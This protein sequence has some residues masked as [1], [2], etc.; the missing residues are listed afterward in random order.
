[1]ANLTSDNDDYSA[2]NNF[3]MR[4]FAFDPD[5]TRHAAAIA[6]LFM[7]L[8]NNGGLNSFLT[9]T[10]DLDSQEVVKALK[11]VGALKAAEQLGKVLD[12]LGQPL[13][14]SSP[15]QRWEVLERFWT[16]ELEEYET[17]SEAADRELMLV[18][19][20]HVRDYEPFYRAL[21]KPIE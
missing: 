14:A 21:G 9:S 13:P 15:A 8:A 19:E 5:E 11:F 4:P 6:N 18:L 20:Q 12:G 16:D 17:L 7:N 3:V 10:C 1:V 2:W